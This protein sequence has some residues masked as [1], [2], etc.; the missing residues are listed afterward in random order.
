MYHLGG[1]DSMGSIPWLLKNFKIPSL[2]TLAESIPGLLESLQI[3][4]LLFL[5]CRGHY[6]INQ[7]SICSANYDSLNQ[8]GHHAINI[9]VH[10]AENYNIF[11]ISVVKLM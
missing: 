5:L 8:L 11:N 2:T 9:S 4:I 3:R 7:E 6:T 10:I 1:I